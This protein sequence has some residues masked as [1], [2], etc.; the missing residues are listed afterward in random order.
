M[1]FFPFSTVI[2]RQVSV[3]GFIWPHDLGQT[4]QL[5]PFHQL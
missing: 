4:E 2:F 3:R 5:L 1:P